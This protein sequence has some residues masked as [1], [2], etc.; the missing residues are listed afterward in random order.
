MKHPAKNYGI[1]LSLSSRINGVMNNKFNLSLL[2]ICSILT[3]SSGCEKSEELIQF[4]IPIEF[5]ITIPAGPADSTIT[6]I[7]SGDL[8]TGIQDA[9]GS[10]G[11][12]SELVNQVFLTS[13]SVELVQPGA[14]SLDFLQNVSMHIGAPGVPI[15][16][17]AWKEPVPANT[18]NTMSMAV[19]DVDLKRH[20]TKDIIRFRT[21]LTTDEGIDSDHTLKI[22]AHFRVNARVRE[23]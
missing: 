4:V 15:M 13:M 16:K 3:L 7:P 1:T 22:S 6:S 11:S 8:E 10:R 12:N 5:N 18:G 9:L 23:S 21:D 19:W 17:T 2:S 20:L 14:G